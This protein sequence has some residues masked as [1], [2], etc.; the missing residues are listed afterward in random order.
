MLAPVLRRCALVFFDDILIYSHPWA[1]HLQHVKAVLTALHEQQLR[2]KCS[3]CSFTTSS[4]AYLGHIIFVD[5]VA[6]D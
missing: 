5:G 2:I 3:K 4:V 6:M 1:S